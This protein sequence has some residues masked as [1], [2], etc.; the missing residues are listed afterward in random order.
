M[1]TEQNIQ[2]EFLGNI[3]HTSTLAFT[4]K[5]NTNI[6]VLTLNIE[7]VRTGTYDK[8]ISYY[9]V[10]QKCEVWET[11]AGMDIEVEGLLCLE[12]RL[13]PG[14]NIPFTLH[15][16]VVPEQYR[17]TIESRLEISS[18][19]AL[20]SYEPCLQTSSFSIENHPAFEMARKSFGFFKGKGFRWLS[21]VERNRAEYQNEPYKEGPWIQR[22]TTEAFTKQ[23]DTALLAPIGWVSD[24]NSHIIA[25]ASDNPYEL[26]I[27]WGPC[28]HS[29]IAADGPHAKSLTA[30]TVV[31]IMPA[32]LPMLTSMF[33]KDF[34]YAEEHVISSR[35][36]IWATDKGILL[37]GLENAM[38]SGWL[39]EGS[40]L[41][42][43]RSEG[44]WT[45]GNLHMFLYPEGVTEGSGSTLWTI[46]QGQGEAVVIRPLNNYLHDNP[47]LTHI[48]L[49]VMDRGKD[50]VVEVSLKNGDATSFRE[51]YQ[52]RW[53]S[54][55]R[56][57]IPL[58]SNSE[59]TTDQVSLEIKVVKTNNPCKIV[60]DNLRGFISK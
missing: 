39:V 8:S 35:P 6:P 7:N 10:S 59:S 31:Y 44:N 3:G 55:R 24:D 36:A 4:S 54:T 28:L 15:M 52:L 42:R 5:T 34:P 19:E 25:T 26:G 30:K 11:D 20:F 2:V 18:D 40:T 17:I 23:G 51:T 38:N 27:R 58:D 12:P 56:I 53:M 16:R 37:D 49:D 32:D 41:E 46:P 13:M 29:N 14:P 9:C 47:D 48:A 45:N 57:V 21:D 33:Q 43:Y 22:F 1:S 50:V 60:L